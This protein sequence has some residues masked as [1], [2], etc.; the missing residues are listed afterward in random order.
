M[1]EN[2]LLFFS[3]LLLLRKHVENIVVGFKDVSL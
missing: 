2:R 1:V 3:L